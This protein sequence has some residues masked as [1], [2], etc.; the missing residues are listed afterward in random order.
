METSASSIIK[1][2]IPKYMV[3]EKFLYNPTLQIKEHSLIL[4]FGLR[5]QVLPHLVESSF[6]KTYI[7]K[8][9]VDGTEKS[10]Q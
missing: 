1:Y 10:L 2:D 8:E 6:D 4:S 3:C 7:L 9:I 5:E